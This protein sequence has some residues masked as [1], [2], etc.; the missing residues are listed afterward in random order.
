MGEGLASFV[1]ARVVWNPREAARLADRLA[2]L[3]AEEE[4]EHQ[5]AREAGE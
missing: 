2:E 3:A 4:R 1:E 5:A